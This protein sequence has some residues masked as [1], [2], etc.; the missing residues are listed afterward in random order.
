[1]IYLSL[2][3]YRGIKYLITQFAHY[4]AARQLV[5][6]SSRQYPAKSHRSGIRSSVFNGQFATVPSPSSEGQHRR[7]QRSY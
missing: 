5:S 4:Q 2:L 7:A 1:M 3:L 6:S